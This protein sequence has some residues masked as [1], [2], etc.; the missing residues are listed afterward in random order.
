MPQVT[1][2]QSCPGNR[3]LAGL[4]GAQR[5]SAGL[6]GPKRPHPWSVCSSLRCSEKTGLHPEARGPGFGGGPEAHPFQGPSIERA[7]KSARGV[8]GLGASAAGCR[9]LCVSLAASAHPHLRRPGRSRGVPSHTAQQSRAGPVGRRP[10]TRLPVR[11]Q[12]RVCHPQA[13]RPQL[14]AEQES[15]PLSAG[16][17]PSLLSSLPPLLRRGENPTT[18]RARNQAWVVRGTGQGPGAWA[19][20]E[21]WPGRRG[22]TPLPQVRPVHHLPSSLRTA[23]L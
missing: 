22:L 21:L 13:A 14:R 3:A 10:G 12:R 23:Q 16:G 1:G 19:V 17:D 8:E 7:Q 20:P 15:E 4:S 2:R 5:G 6:C 11:P 9:G 18:R